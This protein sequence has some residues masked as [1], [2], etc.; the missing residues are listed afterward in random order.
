MATIKNE[1]V[2]Y[3]AYIPRECKMIV[4]EERIGEL[5]KKFGI[6]VDHMHKTMSL[7]ESNREYP[8]RKMKMGTEIK[9]LKIIGAIE[10]LNQFRTHYQL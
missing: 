2:E 5:E 10:N 1:N 7:S 9:Y 8:H 6:T 3:E 4:N